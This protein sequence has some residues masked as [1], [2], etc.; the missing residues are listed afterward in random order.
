MT[1]IDTHT[2]I[3]DP[4]FDLD[5]EAAVQRALE[6]GVGMMLMPNVDAST[7]QPMLETH[8]LFPDC[9][10][11]M[12]GL[13]PEEVK[14]DYKSVL[15][16]MERELDRNIYI[17]VGE[18]GL[19][20]YWDATFEHEQL[21]AFET[22]LGWAKQLHLPLSIHCRNAFSFMARI[23]EKHQDGGLHGVM[24]CFTGSEEEAQVYLD[25][26]F[27]LGL[28]GVTTYK[29]CEVKNFL[30]NI[31]LDR[32]VLETDAPYLSPV[33]HRGKRNEPA[34][35]ADT[36]KRIAEI[37][38]IPLEELAETTTNNVKSLFKI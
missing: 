36:A 33:P 8:E 20:F 10:R 29:N 7:I 12:M 35:M 21:D 2:H 34:F 27:H 4:A 26:G 37:Y 25:L 32:I 18:I 23:L 17:G 5:R 30:C 1:L 31:P 11:V 22:Q 38:Q 9:T 13:Q 28:G 24:H 16:L 14:E 19:D 15:A 6:A 3:Y